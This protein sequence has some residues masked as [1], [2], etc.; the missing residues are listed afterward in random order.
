MGCVKD[1]NHYKTGRIRWYT[2]CMNTVD[3]SDDNLPVT[4]NPWWKTKV[5]LFVG[6]ILFLVLVAFLVAA[7]LSYIV[8]FNTAPLLGGLPT[9]TAPNSVTPASSIGPGPSPSPTS[10]TI[11]VYFSKHP[12]SENDFTKVVAM[13]RTASSLRVAR[14]AFLDLIAGPTTQEQS[15]GLYSEWKLSGNSSCGADGF[16][17]SVNSGKATVRLCR[18]FPSAGVGQDARAQSEADATLKQFST[19]TKTVYLNKDGNCL[20]DLSGQNRCLQ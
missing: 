14:I 17:I 1:P 9:P 20:F 7:L 5:A 10:I 16:T 8:N 4:K 11:N 3:Y 6:V 15:D 12:D 18:D 2:L 19:I 13:Q